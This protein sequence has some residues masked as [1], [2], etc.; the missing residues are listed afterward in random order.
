MPSASAAAPPGPP[1]RSVTRTS[2]PASAAL[3]AADDARGAEADDHDV[4]R[5]VPGADL[6]GVD[7]RH[8]GLAHLTSRPLGPPAARRP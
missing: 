2:A 5:L 1:V 4:G 3:N 8:L 7:R 6:P